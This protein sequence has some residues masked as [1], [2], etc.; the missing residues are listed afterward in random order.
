MGESKGLP[1]GLDGS[2]WALGLQ[3]HSPG[4][5]GPGGTVTRSSEVLPK[6]SLVRFW[7]NVIGSYL[8]KPE[9]TDTKR[10]NLFCN[11]SPKTNSCVPRGGNVSM[12][13]LPTKCSFFI[14]I[15]Q[16][17]DTETNKLKGFIVPYLTQLNTDLTTDATIQQ[18]K[19]MWKATVCVGGQ[20][21]TWSVLHIRCP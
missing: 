14:I 13:C 16:C 12:A 17:N 15:A 11:F 9:L 4:N 19:Q 6:K 7:L 2:W 20:P 3:G 5:G 10:A 1:Q 8:Q 21:T 18:I